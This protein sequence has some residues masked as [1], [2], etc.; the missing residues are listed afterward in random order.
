MEEI[1]NIDLGNGKRLRI[2]HD[3]E[4]MNPRENDNLSVMAFFHNR[5]RLG[6]YDLIRDKGINPKEHSGWD[7]LENT[8]IKEFNPIII[9]PVFLYDHSG[10]K[11]SLG[12][13]EDRWDSGQIGFV[14]IPR[15]K[16]LKTWGKKRISPKIKNQCM[17]ILRGEIEIYNYYLMGECCGFILE[18]IDKTHFDGMGNCH[19][20]ITEL[21]SSW[22]YYGLDPKKNGIQENISIKIP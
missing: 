3:S 16:A 10:I 6:D 8:L 7:A 5:Y 4:A 2:I 11:I 9:K 18:S 20:E 19:E 13:F 17:E 22:G 21:D 15:E 14:L 12:D 1:D